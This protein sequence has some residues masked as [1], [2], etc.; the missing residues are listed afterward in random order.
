MKVLGISSALGQSNTLLSFII[1]FKRP[2]ARSVSRDIISGKRQFPVKAGDKVEVL[3]RGIYHMLL[4]L[5]LPLALPLVWG[6][7]FLLLWVLV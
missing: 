4:V 1:L 3:G 6:L 2:K 7:G 5:V